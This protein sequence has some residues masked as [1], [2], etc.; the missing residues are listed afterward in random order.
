MSAKAR[1]SGAQES[2]KKSARS[3]SDSVP[4]ETDAS[5]DADDSASASADADTDANTDT[6]AELSPLPPDKSLVP[7]KGGGDKKRRFLSFFARLFAAKGSLRDELKEALAGE[8]GADGKPDRGRTA[9]G[10]GRTA[11]GFSPNE[12][13]MLQNILHLTERRVVDVMV[14]RAEINAVEERISVGDLL[15][16]FEKTGHTRLPVYGDTLDDPRGMVLVK[17]LLLHIVTASGGASGSQDGPAKLD[18]SKIDLDQPLGELDIVRS[19]IFV[20]PSMFAA[21]LMNRMQ[22][23][24][25]QMALV[26]DEHGGTDGLV[27]LEDIIEEVVGEIGD[28][29]EKDESARITRISPNV[30][31][32]DARAE[33]EKV[34]E[35]IGKNF[36]PGESGEDMGTIGGLVFAL[37]GHIP[38]RGEIIRGLAGYEFRITDADPRRVR[39][40]QIIHRPSRR[41]AR[42]EGRKAKAKPIF[43]E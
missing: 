27:S 34:R 5:A 30:W 24:R 37:A 28:E 32:V 29:H 9:R 6:D 2:G 7:V 1:E 21:D 36:D 13:A 19:I 3:E 43:R 41:P 35:A 31:S 42:P 40:L 17:D 22:V 16:M 15:Q 4:P 10:K 26:I 8:G 39:Q 12:R 20:P 18:P 33:L 11:E 25:T 23:S 14:A 38:A